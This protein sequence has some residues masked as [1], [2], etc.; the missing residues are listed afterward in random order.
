MVADR[1]HAMAE[2]QVGRHGTEEA[3]VRRRRVS[4]VWDLGRQSWQGVAP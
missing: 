4:Q 1:A 3:A 2:V